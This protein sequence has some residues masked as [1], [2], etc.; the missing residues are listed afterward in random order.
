MEKFN[1]FIHEQRTNNKLVESYE[2]SDHT[3]EIR[4]VL[5]EIKGSNLDTD[6]PFEYVGEEK[7]YSHLM[8]ESAVFFGTEKNFSETATEDKLYFTYTTFSGKAHSSIQETVPAVEYAKKHDNFFKTNLEQ[9]C[10]ATE[11]D[12]LPPHHVI[13]LQGKDEL[14]SWDNLQDIVGDAKRS[15]L[16]NFANAINF[17]RIALQNSIDA[18]AFT[19]LAVGY[20]PTRT[21]KVPQ[22]EKT[23]H[24]HNIILPTEGTQKSLV[25]A[26]NGEIRDH[27]ANPYAFA[28]KEISPDIQNLVQKCF[29]KSEI[30]CTVQSNIDSDN[31]FGQLEFT[32]HP[33]DKVMELSKSLEA[34]SLI[35][36]QLKLIRQNIEYKADVEEL[37]LGN[38]SAIN[39]K[40][41]FINTK[42]KRR[43]PVNP[44]FNVH[45]FWD[46]GKIEHISLAP[47]LYGPA[48]RSR[49]SV[50][51][52]VRP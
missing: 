19:S 22:S 36:D 31:T 23:I 3:D 41:N 43:F 10:S 38:I 47:S 51:R 34:L 4:N 37:F 50:I 20:D 11:L 24:A 42:G 5:S 25:Q 29:S 17:D 13:W 27:F 21:I 52:R 45:I 9:I 16:E 33:K 49:G 48:E 44:S 46:E 14:V 35:Y 26:T 8:K 15:V 7:L 6:S 32:I 12:M 40:L 1:S 18:P 30:S 2:A 28:A 39:E